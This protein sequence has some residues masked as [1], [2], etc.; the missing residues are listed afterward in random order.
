MRVGFA[1]Y[2]HVAVFL[3]ALQDVITIVSTG[4]AGLTR[5]FE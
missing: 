1:R 3:S 2:Q 5:Q 4:A